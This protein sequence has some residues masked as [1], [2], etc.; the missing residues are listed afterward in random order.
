MLGRHPA[1]SAGWIVRFFM[2][3]SVVSYPSTIQQTPQPSTYG[4]LTICRN[5]T[6]SQ[7]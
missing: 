1:N 4:I 3:P 2:A 7:P 5:L 6:A